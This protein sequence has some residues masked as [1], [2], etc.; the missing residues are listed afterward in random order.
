MTVFSF[1]P[2]GRLA[3]AAEMQTSTTPGMT[4]HVQGACR[5]PAFMPQDTGMALPFS[6][7]TFGRRT[8]STPFR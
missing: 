6:F 5:Y 7:A 2:A 1:P 4:A 3:A 8:L